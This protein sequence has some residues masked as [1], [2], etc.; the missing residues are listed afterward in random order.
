M[1]RE[2]E[3]P[4]A[5]LPKK[6]I[7]GRARSTPAATAGERLQQELEELAGLLPDVG[8][9][10]TANQQAVDH[11]L[12]QLARNAQRARAHRRAVLAGFLEYGGGLLSAAEVAKRLD[13]PVA[14]VQARVS[15]GEFVAL[16][17][18]GRGYD[19]PEAQ[20][21]PKKPASMIDGLPAIL[22]VLADAGPWSAAEFLVT[23]NRRLGGAPP[24]K[25]LRRGR[26]PESRV[27]KAAAAWAGLGS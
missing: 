22:R 25:V 4:R 21:D 9:P 27:A 3:E 1:E 15:N 26:A 16:P 12:G 5:E 10:R 13:L 18:L 14:V 8:E 17:T 24:L 23:P 11:V 6:T 7:K 19:F 2:R 20:F